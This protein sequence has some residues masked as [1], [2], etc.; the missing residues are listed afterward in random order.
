MKS[1]TCDGHLIAFD[2]YHWGIEA[3]AIPEQGETI[4]H[5]FIGY[6]KKDK[7]EIVE[8]MKALSKEKASVLPRLRMTNK[9]IKAYASS[10]GYEF[11]DA[12][13]A[14]IIGTSYEGET[15]E[16]AVND[17]LDAFER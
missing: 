11:T 2:C 1:L 7:G 17:F 8:V 10:L 9:E 6:T 12:D 13:C 14:D 15:V 4:R 5:K 16:H 3:W